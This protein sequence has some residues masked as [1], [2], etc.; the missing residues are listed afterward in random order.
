MNTIRVLAADTVQKAESGHPGMP[1]GMAP[2]AHVLWS[3]FL[4]FNPNNPSWPNRDRFLL[5]NGH[6]CALQYI[7]LH[8]SGY[9]VKLDD[10]KQFRQ[11][12][13]LTPGHPEAHVTPGVEVTT[14]PLGQ[15]V[16]NSVGLALAES[17]LAAIYNRDG[18]KLF[19]NY[20]YAFVGDGCL[21]EGIGSEAASLAGH[22]KLNKLIWIYDDNKVSGV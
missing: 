18:F 12:D 3:K 2:V 7:L 22:W 15:G 8:L 21:Q 11:I 19:D 10:L 20:T 5:S 4:K 9:K 14:G 6:G 1:M 17:N 16:A 13:S